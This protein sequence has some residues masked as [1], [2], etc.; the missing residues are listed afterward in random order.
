MAVIIHPIIPILIKRYPDKRKAIINLYNNSTTFQTVCED[1]QKCGEALKHWL[2]STSDEALRRVP[3]YEELM[4]SLEAE[5]TY[6]LNK[7]TQ[8]K[9]VSDG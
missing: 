3:E 1:Y 4:Q 2:E 7:T 5:I 8:K 6:Y 9:T